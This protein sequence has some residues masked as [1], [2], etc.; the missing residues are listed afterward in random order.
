[1]SATFS[2]RASEVDDA[3]TVTSSNQNDTGSS[4][5]SSDD[6]STT[7]EPAPSVASED[8][9]M[10]VQAYGMTQNHFTVTRHALVGGSATLNIMDIY[11]MQWPLAKIKIPIDYLIQ[12]VER[13]LTG[14]ANEISATQWYPAT[15]DRRIKSSAK[16][17]TERIAIYLAKEVA[18]IL[19]PVVSHPLLTQFD[20]DSKPLLTSDF[21]VM[22][23]YKELLY[24]GSRPLQDRSSELKRPAL[25]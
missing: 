10:L 7:D 20:P 5:D 17:L 21:W 2:V 22:P 14:F 12:R 18:S 19:R 15:F 11:P 3:S 25:A 6:S 13:L 9:N 4:S 24:S 23:I 8:H 16:F 1:M